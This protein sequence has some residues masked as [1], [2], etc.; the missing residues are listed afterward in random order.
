MKDTKSAQNRTDKNFWDGLWKAK[1]TGWD[2]K[3]VSPP[4]KEYIDSLINKDIAILIP[5]CGNAYEAEYLMQI[6]FTNVTIIDIAPTLVLG[7]LQKF[8][9]FA[10]KEMTII[11]GDFFKHHGQYDL[12][13]EQTF[14]CALAPGLRKSYVEKMHALLNENRNIAGLLFNKQFESSPPFGGSKEEY[15]K[16]FSQKF[17]I[18]KMSD[19]TTSISPRMGAELFFEMKKKNN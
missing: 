3:K 16:L 17:E 14:F 11:C 18:E 12:I 1:D 6:G 13:L 2:L 7:L 15:I 4:I 8:E 10:G 5:G 19:C 9:P